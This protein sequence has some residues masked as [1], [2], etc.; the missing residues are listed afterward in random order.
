MKKFK[1]QDNAGNIF[2]V[3]AHDRQEAK[4]LALKESKTNL[5]YFID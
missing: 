3:R 1:L 2:V 5:V 4:K